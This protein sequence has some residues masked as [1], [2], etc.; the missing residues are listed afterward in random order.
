MN[1][2]QTQQ[3]IKD[4]LA[5]RDKAAEEAR[6]LVALAEALNW[7]NENVA[8][9]IFPLAAIGSENVDTRADQA[10]AAEKLFE[11]LDQAVQPVADEIK[12]QSKNACQ[13]KKL[14]FDAAKIYVERHQ[15]YEAP[16]NLGIRELYTRQSRTS[17]SAF[18]RKQHWL[19]DVD[20]KRTLATFGYEPGTVKTLPFE[21]SYIRAMVDLELKAHRRSPNPLEPLEIPI[22]LSNSVDGSQGSH[23]IAATI[24]IKP[25]QDDP[26]ILGKIS[27]KITDSL[28]ISPQK[29]EHYQ[30]IMEDALADKP[31]E[32]HNPFAAADGVRWNLA[33][34]NVVAGTGLQTADGHTCGYRALH[35]LLR[36]SEAFRA[37]GNGKAREYAAI[38]AEDGNGLVSA[39]YQAQL[40]GL[41]I[42]TAEYEALGV[43]A[44]GKFVEAFGDAAVRVIDEAKLKDFLAGIKPE[45]DVRVQTRNEAVAEVVDEFTLNSKVVIFP[46]GKQ[47]SSL[48]AS[49]YN[50][51][52]DE[53]SEQLEQASG[54]QLKTI[55]LPYI[56]S[57]ALDGISAFFAEHPQAISD[58]LVY[59]FSLGEM[60]DSK[61]VFKSKLMFNLAKLS[62]AGQNKIELQDSG[63]IFVEEDWLA[64]LEFVKQQ[65][66]TC[67]IQLPTAFAKT[68]LQR[69]FQVA[70]ETAIQRR[71]IK[72]LA[73]DSVGDATGLTT[74]KRNKVVQQRAKIDF[75]NAEKSAE[76]ELQDAIEAEVRVEIAVREVRKERS[77]EVGKVFSGEMILDAI[78]RNDFK[79][80]SELELVLSKETFISRWHTLAGNLAVGEIK[81]GRN[82]GRADRS[83]G[84]NRLAS[85]QV[86]LNSSNFAGISKAALEK[87]MQEVEFPK[88]GIDFEN[89]PVGFVLMPSE[90]NPDNFV[91][92]YEADF[93]DEN[94][95]IFYQ[96]SEQ[97]GDVEIISSVVDRLV[98]G[99]V[100]SEANNFLKKANQKLQN[101]AKYSDSDHHAY[102][103]IMW[104]LASMPEEQKVE[105]FALFG[106]TIPSDL[107]GEELTGE[108]LVSIG[109]YLELLPVLEKLDADS[110]SEED[111]VNYT[112]VDVEEDEVRLQR[113]VALAQKISLSDL[114][115]EPSESVIFN[116]MSSETKAK[117]E[118]AIEPFNL[119]YKEL[120]GLVQV[121]S[122][123]GDAG[124][125]RLL[126]NWQQLS[127]LDNF[128]LGKYQSITRNVDG[129]VGMVAGS[130]MLKACEQVKSFT[131]A[132]KAWFEALYAN[133]E[134]KDS[135][136]FVQMVEQFMRFKAKV[137]S[138]G[139]ELYDISAVDEP[140]TP[141]VNMSVAM[142]R[143]LTILNKC[144]ATERNAQWQ[145]MAQLDL[146]E[147]G[148]IKGLRDTVKPASEH[149][150]KVRSDHYQF[151]LPIMAIERP[152]DIVVLEDYYQPTTGTQELFTPDDI[153]D[154]ERKELMQKN[155]FR[156][157]AVQKH[158]M[159]LDFYL[160]A[161]EQ[162]EALSTAGY[163]DI[164]VRDAQEILYRLLAEM[165]TGEHYQFFIDDEH[166]AQ[167]QWDAIL[168]GLDSAKLNIGGLRKLAY[169]KALGGDPNSK[170]FEE[171]T[172]QLGALPNLPSLSI[173]ERLVKVL[174]SPIINFEG[175]SALRKSLKALSYSN[176]R[177]KAI[178]NVYGDDIYNGMKHY[179]QTDYESTTAKP[180]ELKSKNIDLSKFSDQLTLF[181]Y[182]V[183]LAYEINAYEVEQ[184]ATHEQ[185]FSYDFSR[186][187]IPLV[188]T[189][190]VKIQ[191]VSAVNDAFNAIFDGLDGNSEQIASMMM[192]YIAKHLA[193]IENPEDL[194]PA[195]LIEILNSYQPKVQELS[196]ELATRLP[197]KKLAAEDKL[198]SGKLSEEELKSIYA[199]FSKLNQISN[200]F[201]GANDLK[202]EVKGL[203]LNTVWLKAESE[204]VAEDVVA[205]KPQEELPQT[206]VVGGA[207]VTLKQV[208]DGFLLTQDSITSKFDPEH[209]ATL[210]DKKV[211][212]GDAA[213]RPFRFDLSSLADSPEDSAVKEY[214]QEQIRA[215]LAEQTH[216]MPDDFYVRAFAKIEALSEAGYQ[217]INIREVQ[218]DLYQLLVE[219]TT[220]ENYKLAIND[221]FEAEAKIF[222]LFETLTT[223]KLT[224]S[225]LVGSTLGA[226]A[227]RALG[228]D[229]NSI[230][231]E[232]V[233]SQLATLPKLP[234]LP[235]MQQL[236][237]VITSPIVAKPITGR[238][239]LDKL[240]S[241]LASLQVLN[242]CL[243]HITEKPYGNEFYKGMMNYETALFDRT[244]ERPESI[245]SKVI[246]LDRF[247]QQL[248]L[249]EYHFL[250]VIEL[251]ALNS[252]HT[253]STGFDNGLFRFLLP[254]LST[255]QVKIDDLADLSAAYNSIFDDLT[256]SEQQFAKLML[257]YVSKQLNGMTQISDVAGLI[258]LL[259]SY[260]PIIKQVSKQLAEKAQAEKV[261]LDELIATGTIESEDLGL[262]YAILKLDHPDSDNVEDLAK[263][264][265]TSSSLK[266][267]DFPFLA[268]DKQIQ[269][270]ID[271]ALD[272]EA[273]LASGDI[274]LTHI[275]SAHLEH[276]PQLAGAFDSGYFTKALD[277]GAEGKVKFF[278]DT[279]FKDAEIRQQVDEIRTHFDSVE[280]VEM[281]RLLE[282]INDVL[283]QAK[284]SAEKKEI[285]QYLT[286]ELLTSEPIADYRQ[287]LDAM[288]SVGSGPFIYYMQLS[289]EYLAHDTGEEVRTID[290]ISQK[291]AFFIKDALPNLY[292]G[293]KHLSVVEF[294]PMIASAIN[295]GH[296]E[297]L[298]QEITVDERYQAHLDLARLIKNAGADVIADLL[299]QIETAP[300]YAALRE[301]VTSL[302]AFGSLKV[303]LEDLATEA[304]ETITKN[305]ETEISKQEYDAGMADPQENVR[306]RTEETTKER[307]GVSGFFMGLIGNKTYTETKYFKITTTTREELV[308]K[309]F[310]AKLLN[311]L[312]QEITNS[313]G[314]FITYG[315]ALKASLQIVDDLIEKYPT[316][317]SLIVP[318]ASE[319]IGYQQQVEDESAKDAHI[320]HAYTQLT[321]LA[322]ELN[323]LQ[324]KDVVISLC[325]HFSASGQYNFTDLMAIFNGQ[326]PYEKFAE[327]STE[328]KVTLFKAVT[329]L[330][331]ND[332]ACSLENIQQQLALLAL[333]DGDIYQQALATT[334][335]KAPFPELSQM[336]EWWEKPEVAEIKDE[337]KVA[338]LAK[339][340][341]D[342]STAPVSREDAVNGFDLEF[343]KTKVKDIGGRQYS[344][345]ELK[346]L[347]AQVQK[348]RTEPTESLLA[349]I[350]QYRSG[351]KDSSSA[352][353][354]MHLTALMAELLYRTK[355][356]SEEADANGNRKYGRSFEI[357]TTQYLALYSLLSSDNSTIAGIGTGEG[358]S[359]I[360]MLSIAAQWAMGKTVD[361]VTAD[362]SLATRDY[363]EYQAFFSSFGAETNLI[364]AQTPANEYRQGGIN[365]SDP[366]NL[367][368]FRN[369]ARSEGNSG[370][371]L[372]AERAQRCLLLDEAD[373]TLFDT[374]D[375]RY[376]YSAQADKSI[377]DMPWVYEDLVAFFEDKIATPSLTYDPKELGLRTNE[378]C[379]HGKK[380]DAEECNARFN[381]FIASKYGANSEH[382]QRIKGLSRKQL[383]A[384]QKSALVALNLKYGEDFALEAKVSI[385]TKQG[386][387]TVNQARFIEGGI[388]SKTAKF[389]FG[390]HQCLHA[391]LNRLKTRLA[392]SS[393]AVEPGSLEEQL[394]KADYAVGRFPVDSENQI[395]YSSSSKALTDDYDVIRGV[396]GTPGAWVE[397]AEKSGMSFIDIPRHR[398]LKRKDSPYQITKDS[399]A[400]HQVILNS[401][402][403]RIA[404]QQP[405][406]LICENDT[407]SQELASF[408]QANL[409]EEEMQHFNRVD[410]STSIKD[411]QEIVENEAGRPGAITIA[412]ARLGRG[413]DIKLHDE[414]KI[415][416]LHVLG[417]YLPRT[418]D[419]IQIVGRAG[420]FGAEGSTQFVFNADAMKKNGMVPEEL[421][422]ATEDYLHQ[423]QEAADLFVQ[424]QRIIKDAVGDFRMSLT[425]NFFEDFYRA[426][427]LDP[428]F[429]KED[430]VDNWRKFFDDSDKAWNKAWPVIA[431]ALA[432]E[433]LDTVKREIDAYQDEVVALWGGMKAKLDVV[434]KTEFTDA[435]KAQADIT[436]VKI[437]KDSAALIGYKANPAKQLWAP[438]IGEGEYSQAYD[439]RAVV[440]DGFW[441]N[442][443]KNTWPAIKCII[444][445]WFSGKSEP[446]PFLKAWRNNNITTK[447]FLRGG[448]DLA[449]KAQIEKAKA[450]KLREEHPESV[451]AVD[452][453][454]PSLN[455]R[456]TEEVTLEER[457]GQQLDRS[458]AKVMKIHTEFARMVD[459]PDHDDLPE[460]ETLE[461]RVELIPKTPT[462]DTVSVLDDELEQERR[463]TMPTK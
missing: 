426:H 450:A 258:T 338:E 17:D 97:K 126:D 99:L 112:N 322:Q 331:N 47:D 431:E 222:D 24:T 115:R 16:H 314:Q 241:S 240:Q 143:M 319:L 48:G 142:A 71:N 144:K 164:D 72:A 36:D 282:D 223:A 385:I 339:L 197:A 31:G 32:F 76:I 27:Y 302:K 83:L 351:E 279:N 202:T 286:D 98:A 4:Y 359:R 388:A 43:C 183:V 87:I 366:A 203:L 333:P 382:A 110:V 18:N 191:D 111:F 283:H 454:E 324:N 103:Q 413:T 298:T 251:D 9:D 69:Q 11:F 136:D 67:E 374:V 209:V 443:R 355:G 148:A 370:L 44:R 26:S 461:E 287:L 312:S 119:T 84:I 173:M 57:D 433:D 239:D 149:S 249:F 379:F 308:V 261:K 94:S 459:T 101:S 329:A 194:D 451:E 88:G 152:E 416:G 151:I 313:A 378:E 198:R 394:K 65:N 434:M 300:Q 8:Q 327:L 64:I 276:L 187:L 293:F 269:S 447:Q 5:S 12:F 407:E 297:E 277:R 181:D 422:T 264:F 230:I 174:T 311:A 154:T 335:S 38:D 231:L 328:K 113:M 238:G 35:T 171:I 453:D 30:Q 218:T 168:S 257:Q 346:Q 418:R 347:S 361:F 372:P 288:L 128:D 460:A 352:E 262:F 411:E 177:L 291:A 317:K 214:C 39:V 117:V 421:F 448:D 444:G 127:A 299:H 463:S 383:E 185:E 440:I 184:A 133:H 290:N 129:Y 77:F 21:S 219:L 157:V 123:Y 275:L 51:F 221:D 228:G 405:I 186:F 424:K 139:L 445:G 20:V 369:K 207:E 211:E 256:L 159:P 188:S 224:F 156:F 292:K 243:K 384:W 75:E 91:L 358:K 307:G 85:Q 100:V 304:F 124:I 365:F 250:L 441:E 284:S 170:I 196:K 245:N 109:K 410:A 227:G 116:L 391:R 29:V 118:A 42:N 289:K 216:K 428:E 392:S 135:A 435:L 423:Q 56:N 400:Q 166:Q 242:A 178:A 96:L 141:G 106:I 386:P 439:G 345:E 318:F 367:S 234:S 226:F 278:L 28:A 180:A 309:D 155:F 437:S 306:Y 1:G 381:A 130:A 232:Q 146:S 427:H 2:A 78:E 417:T 205:T 247:Q 253:E 281:L 267:E 165:T 316:A 137:A 438:V 349:E 402:R 145:V 315:Y 108:L 217:G 50:G 114:S 360:M 326:A 41:T 93:R 220:G 295:S 252:E 429:N 90:D 80:L 14:T 70:H 420:R 265:L 82:T 160:R 401:V 23:W 263:Y 396:T 158:R 79:S 25:A 162:I 332:K 138:D 303:H 163:K 233:V 362:V 334:F 348:V 397:R 192:T 425:K 6:Y 368:L 122:S 248:N 305:V 95:S 236:V 59:N 271:E 179:S 52:F 63:N 200:F 10:A 268:T 254:N 399:T 208:M 371:V 452:I 340:Y 280:E 357:N 68:A 169:E 296:G 246:P 449:G 40:E 294:A 13:I 462:E 446:T 33:N 320:K 213:G 60:D 285:L 62:K 212:M 353:S 458:L 389:S 66:I 206:T 364:T 273:P 377:S 120:Q 342:W 74:T 172:T 274:D 406:L 455:A 432:N 81:P 125:E 86:V 225:G 121:Y 354:K 193:N 266:S 412:T 272:V 102:K 132:D 323:N 356:L 204:P 344:D 19:T 408:L 350:A 398:G 34:D 190:K 325:E 373:K 419:Y 140:F 58:T 7:V 61:S 105:L 404:N 199:E 363:L 260:K 235:I 53:L 153:S 436:P 457:R 270:P 403:E 330:L 55:Q 104:Q 215:F 229:P 255:F 341:K 387:A 390:V 456:D 321:L 134:P 376:N 201:N 337:D 336:K 49:E 37:R 259:E 54:S 107:T 415:A 395:I 380:S 147:V 414:S 375:T 175:D 244:Y 393:E 343:A 237:A 131:G 210:A 73:Q 310:D 150:T 46:K 45:E 3:I 15:L 22:M 92:H 167:A 430:A 182:H 176:K 89:L 189:F 409:T 442:F 161:V 195:V 301:G